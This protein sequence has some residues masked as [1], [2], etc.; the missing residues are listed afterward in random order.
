MGK[1]RAQS[2]QKDFNCIG[3]WISWATQNSLKFRKRFRQGRWEEAGL[4]QTC[5]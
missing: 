3:R 5:G 4:D 2:E 1:K